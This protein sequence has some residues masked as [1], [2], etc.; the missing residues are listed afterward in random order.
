MKRKR[1]KEFYR[2]YVFACKAKLTEIFPLSNI[3]FFPSNNRLSSLKNAKAPLETS[4]K[5][6]KRRFLEVP[7]NKKKESPCGDSFKFG[8]EKIKD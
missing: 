2:T 7:I 1:K 6:T 3:M 5:T 4:R 8:S